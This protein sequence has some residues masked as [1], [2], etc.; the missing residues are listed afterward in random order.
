MSGAGN[1]IKCGGPACSYKSESNK[2]YTR[3]RH[4]KRRRVAS[5]SHCSSYSLTKQP[6]GRMTPEVVETYIS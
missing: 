6:I 2:S 4:R 3:S 1:A 5:R